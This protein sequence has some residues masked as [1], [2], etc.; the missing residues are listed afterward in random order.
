MSDFEGFEQKF[1]FLENKKINT[2]VYGSAR[3]LSDLS[4]KSNYSLYIIKSTVSFWP[5]SS[6]FWSLKKI[7]Q[8][9]AFQ[10]RRIFCLIFYWK[11][12]PHP[13]EIWFFKL[14]RVS[15]NVKFLDFLKI[16]DLGFAKET[17]LEEIPIWPRGNND[18]CF[19]KFNKVKVISTETSSMKRKLNRSGARVSTPQVKLDRLQ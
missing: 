15:W 9:R 7:L 8:I 19:P 5:I 13:R 12:M 14:G 6:S 2:A 4:S 10:R 16:W 1:R 18:S 17:I 3:D 11:I